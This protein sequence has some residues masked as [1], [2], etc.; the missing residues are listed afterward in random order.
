MQKKRGACH[1]GSNYNV[2]CADSVHCPAQKV[3]RKT[4]QRETS[5]YAL[6]DCGSQTGY[7]GHYHADS[8]SA[9]GE[10]LQ[11][12]KCDGTGGKSG[13]KLYEAAG[14][15][16]TG[17]PAVGRAALSDGRACGRKSCYVFA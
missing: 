8:Q 10:P 15:T 6:A 11:R 12:F 1:E 7:A 16:R 14:T 3:V 9:A 13:T 4:N 2:F 17:K 5:I